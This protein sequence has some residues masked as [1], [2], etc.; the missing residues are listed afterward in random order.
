MIQGD[1][2]VDHLLL[3]LADGG[4]LDFPVARYDPELGA[5]AEIVSDL[6]AMD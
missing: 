1:H 4:H 2:S 5:P 6:C 3:A